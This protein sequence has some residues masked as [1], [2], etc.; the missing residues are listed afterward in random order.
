MTTNKFEV[1]TAE[2]TD[3]SA[4]NQL[5]EAS[6]PAL[7]KRGYDAAVIR[8]ALPMMTKSNPALLASGTY[9]VAITNDEEIVGCG[10]WTK[11]RPGSE[12]TASGLAH[13]R[14]FGTHPKWVRQGVG[15]SI[16]A[17][18]EADAAKA[19]IGRFEC[20]ASV[21]AVGFYAALGFRRVRE[22]SVPMG[23]LAFP[24]ILMERR[25]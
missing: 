7:M 8:A 1:R 14:H 6:Y 11:E 2:P 4:V 9:Y 17:R 5:L 3:E 20:Y 10:G 25:I 18:C 15:R 23:P 24:V 16:Y 21:N 22:M 12:E 19:A 13:I